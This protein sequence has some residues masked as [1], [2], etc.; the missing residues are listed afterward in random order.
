MGHAENVGNKQEE[1]RE[2]LLSANFK[3]ATHSL[4]SYGRGIM[5]ESLAHRNGDGGR[6]LFVA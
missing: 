6:L 1:R 4:L 5:L 3:R 2:R